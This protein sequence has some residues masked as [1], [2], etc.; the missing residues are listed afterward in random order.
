VDALE[1]RLNLSEGYFSVH[2]FFEKEKITF[3]LL[4]SLP[5]SNIGRKLTGRKFP[6]RSLE[7]M[8]S[9][10]LGIFLWMW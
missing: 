3:T 7:Y 10:P 1:K 5:K 9:S 4:K 2:N 8:G 6:Q